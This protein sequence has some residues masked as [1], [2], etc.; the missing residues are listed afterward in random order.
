MIRNATTPVLIDPKLIDLALLEIQEGLIA[1]LP[2]LNV[3]HGKAKAIKS[4]KNNVEIVGPAVYVGKA[5][6]LPVFPDVHQG[7]FSFFSV[8]D[9]EE[10]QSE[11]LGNYRFTSEVGLIFWFDFRKIY[12]LEWQE[13]TIDNVKFD[14]ITAIKSLRLRRSTLILSRTWEKGENIYREYTDREI[15]NQFL[16]RP[17][18]GLRFDFDITYNEID[19]C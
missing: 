4:L 12:P 2:W 13:R 11:S 8:K 6:Y 3:A 15:K 14:I 16:M 7:C 18:G 5:E 10:V 1:S 9:G 17:Y 19:N